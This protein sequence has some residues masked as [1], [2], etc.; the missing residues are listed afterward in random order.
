MLNLTVQRLH[1]NV[2]FIGIGGISMSALAH[3]LLARGIKVSGSDRNETEIV[4]RLR[5]AG[6]DITI[7][8]FAENIKNPDLVVYT[9]AIS[10]DNPE[11]ISAIEKGIETLER[12][13][14]LG[15]LMLEYAKPIAIS[16]THG[17]TTTTSMLSCVLL[18]AGLNPTVLVGGELAQIK[19]NYHIGSDE[20]LVFEACEYVDSFLKF[21]PFVAIVLNVEADHLDYFSGIEQIK[22]SFNKFISKVPQNGFIV[23]NN[24]DENVMECANGVDRK[25][26]TY[27]I[28][29][30][31]CDYS[32][33][34][35]NFADNGC[36]SFDVVSIGE[37]LG[38]VKLS[39][40]GMHN[41]SNAL[42]VFATAYNLGVGIK[43]IICGISEFTGTRRRFEKKGEVNGAKVYDDYAHHPTEI[44]ATLKAALNIPHNKIWCIFQPHTYTRT[45]A[46]LDDFA[47]ALKVADKVIIADIYAAREP[48]NGT[49]HSRDL[50]TKIENA[51]YM[52]DFEEIAEYVRRNVEKDDIVLTMGAGNINEIAEKL[53]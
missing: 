42:A 53:V 41:V 20:H 45:K 13:D 43:D 39:V 46:L 28:N 9:A 52:N 31:N 30:L 48:N 35:I 6:A 2:H 8:H 1:K 3:I 32:A 29:A 44:T 26:I 23:L 21:N 16:G 22:N 24:D 47:T 38:R 11:L 7:G 12:A 27:G 19:G 51:M 14:F 10:K 40:T 33:Q 17:K 34:N 37:I 18:S 4:K 5:D 50:V 25:K 36:A 49:V 15:E